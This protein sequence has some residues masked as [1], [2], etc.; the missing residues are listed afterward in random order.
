MKNEMITLRDLTAVDFDTIVSWRNDPQVNRYLAER[1]KSRTEIEAWFARLKTNPHTWLK[2]VLRD[3]RL[4]GYCTIESI[5]EKNRK[6]ELALV[7]GEVNCWGLGIGRVVLKK[8]LKYAFN[9]LHMHRVWAV[10]AKGN[11]RSERLMRGVGFS[12]E[13]VM[14][15]ALIIAGE[16]TDLLCYSLLEKEYREVNNHR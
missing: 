1:L 15:E 9:D 3:R 10:V 7:I 4:I 5:D 12:R 8:M 2:A 11:D 14:R 13:G 6:C 16:F